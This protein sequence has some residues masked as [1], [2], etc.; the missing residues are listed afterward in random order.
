M[1]MAMRRV[2]MAMKMATDVRWW[3][4]YLQRL[5][6]N[7]STR[8]WCAKWLAAFRPASGAGVGWNPIAHELTVSGFASLGSVLNGQQCQEIEHFFRQRE[9][10]DPYRPEMG[11]FPL[12]RRDPSAHVIHHFA[13]DVL[14]APYLLGLANRRDILEAAEGFLGCKPTIGYMTAWW[15]FPTGAGPQHAERFHRDV[16]DWRFVK[17]F[18]YLTP[19]SVDSGPHIYVKGS[20]SSSHLLQNRR[21]DEA[22]VRQY[23][24]DDG[25]LTVTGAAGDAFLENTFGIHKGLPVVRGH[26]LVFQVVYSMFSLPYGPRR[27]VDS[28]RHHPQTFDR[29]TNRFYIGKV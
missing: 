19:V 24:G 28:W 21:F 17:L 8:Q 13:A 15:S 4:F 10:H 3:K 11:S 14:H 25:H 29:W 27:P 18:I 7:P 20:A 6:T 12:D 23:F 22:E 16:D 26:R 5:F 2:R 9:V 1:S